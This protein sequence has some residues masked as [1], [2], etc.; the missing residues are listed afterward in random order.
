M[1][2][3]SAIASKAKSIGKGALSSL[4]NS[5]RTNVLN[6]FSTVRKANFT[7][8]SPNFDIEEIVPVQ[9]N[10]ND[11]TYRC[12]SRGFNSVG[13]L[14]TKPG[15]EVRGDSISAEYVLE[16][17]LY[18]D[19]YDEYQARTLSGFLGSLDDFHLMNEKYSSLAKLIQ[20]SNQN[21][22]GYVF[23]YWGPF[24]IFG[25]LETI[26]PTYKAFSQWGQPLKA[27]ANVT[28]K[29]VSTPKAEEARDMAKEYAK[30]QGL[31]DDVKNTVLTGLGT[32]FR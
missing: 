19:F 7:L 21:P 22:E 20:F 30:S 1:G 15:E 28:I 6:D 2:L 4:T 10:P 14:G 11:I 16:M 3:G 24:K 27:T 32:A 26:D 31:F 25:R 5:Y 13:G 17:T 12:H 18:Y 8:L 23:F 29:R 9:I